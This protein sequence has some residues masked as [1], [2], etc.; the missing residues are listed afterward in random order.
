MPFWNKHHALKTN[1][2]FYD[3][4]KNMENIREKINHVKPMSEE[5]SQ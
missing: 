2:E 1:M 5:Q 4:S 3:I